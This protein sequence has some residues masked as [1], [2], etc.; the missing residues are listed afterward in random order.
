MNRIFSFT[1]SQSVSQKSLSAI[2]PIVVFSVRLCV[3]CC[4]L[5]YYHYD[6][7]DYDYYDYD[8]T[9]LAHSAGRHHLLQPPRNVHRRLDES[10]GRFPSVSDDTHTIAAPLPTPSPITATPPLLAAA[11]PLWRK[12]AFNQK[13]K[14]K[15]M[16]RISY[17]KFRNAGL[18]A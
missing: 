8:F 16:K 13:K 7:Y 17:R 9:F 11:P 1:S 2:T 15:D 4:S 12:S 3:R 14:K 5:V 6:Y 10:P 18:L